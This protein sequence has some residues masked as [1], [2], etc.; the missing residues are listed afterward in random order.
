MSTPSLSPA[1]LARYSRHL[2][3]RE[4]GIP[5]QEKL[6]A[7]KVLLVGAGGLGSPAALYLAAS[8]VGTI[9]VIDNDRV[10]VSNLQRQVLYDTQSVG[11][12]K[13]EVAKERLLALN[14]EIELVSHTVELRAANVREIFSKYDVV[15]D[16]TDRFNTRYLSNDACVILRKPLVSAA[17]HRFEGQAMTY[18]PG[19]APCYRCLFP[20]PPADGLVPNCAEAGVLG[21]LPGVMGTIQATE[22]I[23]VIVGVGEP[24]LG[25]L[26]TYDA[27]AMRFGEF[28]FTR[29]P[30]CAVCGD[31]PTI[32]EPADLA[33][34]CSAEVTRRLS[35]LELRELLGKVAIVDVRSPNEF[36]ASHLPGAV[37]IPVGEVER[38]LAEIPRD[39]LVV[40]I[41][42]SGG[43][44]LTASAVAT[45]AGMTNVA[46][47][48]G[49]LLAWAK[50]L[51]PSFVVA[52]VG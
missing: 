26:L 30:D 18:I 21:V 43:R 50:E 10:D 33:E 6:K 15:L 5:G 48:E 9:G 45:R 4:I 38:R 27:L 24:L 44:S 23:K 46:D 32:H 28:R 17:I 16:G 13:A 31:H 42:R 47:L 22:A 29:R 3:L 40:F 35:P 2:A 51:D 12:P 14:P 52:P 49:G 36:R 34:A 8:G 11:R 37:S 39:Q 1:D 20:E 7:A 41:C 25:R 19:Q